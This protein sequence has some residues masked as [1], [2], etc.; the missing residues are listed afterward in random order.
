MSNDIK[1]Q[2]QPAPAALGRSPHRVNISQRADAPPRVGAANGIN[3]APVYRDGGMVFRPKAFA[4]FVRAAAPELPT[5]IMSRVRKIADPSLTKCKWSRPLLIDSDPPTEFDATYSKQTTEK[6]LTEAR[7]HIS[8]FRKLPN[9]SPVFSR[10]KS[11]K[12]L[13]RASPKRPPISPPLAA[14]P[15]PFLPKIPAPTIAFLPGSDQNI[16][17]DVTYRK[18]RT[19]NFLPGA[20]T[21]HRRIHFSAKKTLPARTKSSSKRLGFRPLQH[22]QLPHRSQRSLPQP[23]PSPAS[24]SDC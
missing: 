3:V 2:P 14:P 22:A 4:F 16:E 10:E 20:T 19:E 15:R 5:Q 21:T 6:F 23:P 7:T 8:D 11:S 17:N 1:S 9:L 12:T 24:P 18:Q 13:R